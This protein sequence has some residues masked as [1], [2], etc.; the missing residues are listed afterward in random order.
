LIGK[1]GGWPPP[2]EY[3]MVER[4]VNHVNGGVAV[5]VHGQQV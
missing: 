1:I 4:Q 5:G 3:Q 2:T